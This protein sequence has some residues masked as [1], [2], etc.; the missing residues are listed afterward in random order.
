MKKI[1]V[2]MVSITILGYFNSLY[3]QCDNSLHAKSISELNTSLPFFLDENHIYGNEYSQEREQKAIGMAIKIIEIVFPAESLVISPDVHYDLYWPG[4][5][6][7]V[8]EDIREAFKDEILRH[9]AYALKYDYPEPAFSPHLAYL[10]DRESSNSS[11][12]ADLMVLISN[13]MFG[14][15][16]CDVIPNMF[17]YQFIGMY[18][19]E[20]FLFKYNNEGVVYQ[21]YRSRLI[22]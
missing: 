19:Y 7:I 20:C 17:D 4:E 14:M 3:C 8:E 21:V 10:F 2:I 15:I 12:K 11:D 6:S 16:V 18:E 1:G 22:P 5:D 9:Y 13:P